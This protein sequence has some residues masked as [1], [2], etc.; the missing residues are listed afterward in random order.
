MRSSIET[1]IFTVEIVDVTVYP[2]GVPAIYFIRHLFSS[3]I[4]FPPVA[5][6][7]IVITQLFPPLLPR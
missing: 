2:Y 4:F 3:A 1:F 7:I 6:L 5:L